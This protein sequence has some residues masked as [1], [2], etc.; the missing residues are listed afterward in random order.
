MTIEF[1]PSTEA[2]IVEFFG[3][4]PWGLTYARAHSVSA[5]VDGKVVGLGGVLFHINGSVLGF[6]N[7]KE[8]ARRYPV[9]LHKA[10][11]QGLAEWEK[12]GHKTLRITIEQSVPRAKAWAASLGFVPVDSEDGV[13]V[14]RAAT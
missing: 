5:V 13:W 4:R 2:D 11:K 14:W 7:L 8:E 1:R 12:M 3:E 6:A 9:A 10:V